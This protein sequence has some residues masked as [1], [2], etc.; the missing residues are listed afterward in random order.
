MQHSLTE[1]EKALVRRYVRQARVTSPAGRTPVCRRLAIAA[2]GLMRI[3]ERTHNEHTNERT[4]QQT[5]K[6]DGS[7]YLLVDV[8]Y[9]SANNKIGR[10]NFQ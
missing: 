3:N 10:R 1:L 6:H 7:Q 5:N 4:N 8:K 9:T 2:G